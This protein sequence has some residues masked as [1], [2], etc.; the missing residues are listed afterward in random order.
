[1]GLP[2]TV[3][4]TVASAIPPLRQGPSPPLCDS[5]DTCE[6]EADMISGWVARYGLNGHD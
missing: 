1:M 4:E 5:C 6:T 3:F 2:P